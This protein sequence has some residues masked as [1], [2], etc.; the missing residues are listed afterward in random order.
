MKVQVLGFASILCVASAGLARS[1]LADGESPYLTV[2]DPGNCTLLVNG[3]AASFGEIPYFEETVVKLVPNSGYEFIGWNGAV[4]FGTATNNPITIKAGKVRTI[5]AMVRTYVKPQLRE[6][7][8]GAA[9]AWTAGSMI[10]Q[11]RVM[12]GPNDDV[13]IDGNNGANHAITAT[14]FITCKSLTLKNKAKV[15][16]ATGNNMSVGGYKGTAALKGLPDS[17]LEA[18]SLL[19]KGDLKIESGSQLAVGGQNWCDTANNYYDY[20]SS[21]YRSDV[22]IGGNVTIEG[23]GSKML[24]CAGPIDE[25]FTPQTGCGFLTVEGCLAIASGSSLYLASEGYTGGSVFVRAA[26]VDLAEGGAINADCR[27]FTGQKQA[28]QNYLS[29]QAPGLG[30]GTAKGGGYGGPGYIGSWNVAKCPEGYG[31]TYG[32]A[33]APLL[34]GSPSGMNGN[35][36]YRM[37]AAGGG[38]VRVRAASMNLA[39]TVTANGDREYLVNSTGGVEKYGYGASGGGIWLTT[40]TK[41]L[42]IAPTASLLAKGGNANFDAAH[43]GGGRIAITKNINDETEKYMAENGAFPKK[44]RVRDIDQFH[45]AYPGVTVDVSSPG[46]EANKGTFAYV[47]GTDYGLCIILR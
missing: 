12:P 3:E 46:G 6:N 13:V 28:N 11:G 33:I 24:V 43:G 5:S 32:N 29:T 34:P 21:P 37:A 36:N 4:P 9:G 25:N 14:G 22:R 44:R 26:S 45:E 2:S 27:G 40:S 35:P 31:S 41:A 1:A 15:L 10:W 39:G 38:L 42:T 19:I 20:L 7:F 30:Y 23:S 18:V 16:I 17:N 47:D 8:L